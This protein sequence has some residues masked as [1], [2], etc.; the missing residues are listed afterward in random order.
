MPPSTVV[1]NVFIATLSTTVCSNVPIW[2]DGALVYVGPLLDKAWALTSDLVA[3][4]LDISAPARA[5]IVENVPYFI[6]WV[7][8][9]FYF[10]TSK[11]FSM[12]I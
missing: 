9:Y 10:A 7:S 4:A 5:W 6:H 3:Y 1:Y 8:Y 11:N 2:L 12:Q